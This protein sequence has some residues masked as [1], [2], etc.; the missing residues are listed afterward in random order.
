[1]M[2]LTGTTSSTVRP[3]S[4]ISMNNLD[5]PLKIGLF[6]GS[7][8][9]V[10]WGHIFT[11]FYAL[12]E[13]QLDK[14]WFIPV[15]NHP[16]GKKLSPYMNRV[17][18]LREAIKDMNKYMGGAEHNPLCV[19]LIENHTEG[20]NYTSDTI[21]SLKL[22]APGW[23]F[24]FIVGADAWLH[25]DKWKNLERIKADTEEIIII[26]R[27][28]SEALGDESQTPLVMPDMSSSHIRNLYRRSARNASYLVNQAQGMM[29]PS[30]WRMINSKGYYLEETK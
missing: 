23:K 5:K 17:H 16:F 1:L 10:H 8:D 3:G 24:Y 12:M 29:P 2:R 19:S 20:P 7:F 11:A 14:I 4:R 15:G 25:R 13:K 26:N 21:G 18:L 28:G 22:V 27:P 9:P 6:G 30:V